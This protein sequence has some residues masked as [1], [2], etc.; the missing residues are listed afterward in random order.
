MSEK[1]LV[2]RCDCHYETV[3]LDLYLDFEDEDE[4]YLTISPYW[5]Q[6]RYWR[7]RVG[8]VWAILRGKEYYFGSVILKAADVNRMADFLAEYRTD[9]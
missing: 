1:S 7:E 6:G 5:N 4:N 3:A 2:L 8:A 9:A